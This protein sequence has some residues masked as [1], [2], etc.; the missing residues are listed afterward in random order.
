[1]CRYIC[2]RRLGGSSF[3]EAIREN[4]IKHADPRQLSSLQFILLEK[5]HKSSRCCTSKPKWLTL[6]EK[7]ETYILWY[8]YIHT[9]IC[10]YVFCVCLAYTVG[11][12]CRKFMCQACVSKIQHTLTYKLQLYEQLHMMYACIY[13]CLYVYMFVCINVLQI[14]YSHKAYL[15]D[16]K[17]KYAMDLWK[18]AIYRTYAQI[19]I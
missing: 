12:Y 2:I 17:A 11:R 8:T 13:V 15:P 7:I 9:L 14:S 3:Y 6:C 10:K 5:I 1:M 19:A 16:F 18:C 4:R